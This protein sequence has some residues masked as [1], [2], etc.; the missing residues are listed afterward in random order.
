MYAPI[1]RRGAGL[2]VHDFDYNGAVA[3][4]PHAP[5]HVVGGR[6]ASYRARVARE[7]PGWLG[8]LEALGFERRYDEVRL[9]LNSCMGFWLR[10]SKERGQGA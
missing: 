3:W 7:K 10:T 4:A 5:A 1:L 6:H 8:T 9:H 2:L